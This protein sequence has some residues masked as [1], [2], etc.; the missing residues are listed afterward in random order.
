MCISVKLWIVVSE[1]VFCCCDSAKSSYVVMLLRQV[2]LTSQSESDS[3]TLS[4][5]FLSVLRIQERFFLDL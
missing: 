2:S 4:K 3:A 5:W 1:A